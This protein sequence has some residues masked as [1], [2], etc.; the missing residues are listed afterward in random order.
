MN[1]IPI[2][3]LDKIVQFQMAKEEA[4]NDY[5]NSTQ[6]MIDYLYRPDLYEYNMNGKFPHEHPSVQKK[7]KSL[8]RS[9]NSLYH[10]YNSSLLKT[11]EDAL[12]KLMK[13]EKK[14]SNE[15]I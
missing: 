7:L 4:E 15:S 1:K 14:S 8:N 11:L 2:T 13:P 10:P 6:G 5:A 9:I 3:W 12:N